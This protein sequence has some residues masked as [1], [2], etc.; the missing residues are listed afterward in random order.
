M[1]GNEEDAI[2]AFESEAVVACLELLRGGG[3]GEASFASS[4]AAIVVIISLGAHFSEGDATLKQPF[5]SSSSNNSS[6]CLW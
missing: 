6:C 2:E 4:S 3:D 5:F 1:I